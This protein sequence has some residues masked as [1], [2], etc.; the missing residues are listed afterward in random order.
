MPSK[1]LGHI[2]RY[3]NSSKIYPSSKI[4]GQGIA[5]EVI[6]IGDM[7]YSIYKDLQVESNLEKID[8]EI[9]GLGE[10]IAELNQKLDDLSTQ[11]ALTQVNIQTYISS[12]NVQNYITPIKTAYSTTS[13]VGLV[14]YSTQAVLNDS[15]SPLAVPLSTLQ[16]QEKVY[17]ANV[18]ILSHF[19]NKNLS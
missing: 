13:E 16:N 8:E 3:I 9:Q 5:F 15:N 4:S 1:K 10:E 6:E 19:F 14:Y 7:L 2:A 18:T 12:L 11:L 17:I